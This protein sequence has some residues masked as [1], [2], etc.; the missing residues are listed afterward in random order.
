MN[1]DEFVAVQRRKRAAASTEAGKAASGAAAPDRA[2]EASVSAF[3]GSRGFGLTVIALL[4]V[5]CAAMPLSLTKADHWAQFAGEGAVY[6][7]VAASLVELLLSAAS[8]DKFRVL[9]VVDAVLQAGL[10][11]A[12]FLRVAQDYPWLAWAPFA[13][14]FRILDCIAAFDAAW[15]R[16]LDASEEDL[17]AARRRA[18]ELTRELEEARAS[19]TREDETNL[20]LKEALDMREEDVEML[21]AALQIAAQQQAEWEAGAE[22]G[23]GRRVGGAAGAAGADATARPA[24]AGAAGADATARPAAAGAGGP[25]KAPTGSTAGVRRRGGK[26]IVVGEDMSA[27]Q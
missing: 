15:Q 11:L 10:G 20:R 5:E 13:R 12:L 23:A 4:L 8:V 26:R 18:G 3:L 21:T 22:A 25:A 17:R 2:P 6:L 7:A 9:I 1:F 14:S 19:A 27:T 24:A 16:L